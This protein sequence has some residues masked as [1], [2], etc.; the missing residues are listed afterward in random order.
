M[1]I[2]IQLTEAQSQKLTQYID[3]QFGM[4]LDEETSTDLMYQITHCPELSIYEL[5]V[6]GYGKIKLGEVDVVVQ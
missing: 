1:N 5:V 4:V 6:S 3:N 2:I